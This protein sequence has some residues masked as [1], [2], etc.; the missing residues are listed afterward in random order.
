MINGF[1]VRT[2]EIMRSTAFTK[3]RIY[4]TLRFVNSKAV[5][6][7]HLGEKFKARRGNN[8]II[9][10]DAHIRRFDVKIL[11]A[12]ITNCI[13][14]QGLEFEC[15][16]VPHTGELLPSNRTSALNAVMG[17]TSIHDVIPSFGQ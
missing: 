11:T 8:N 17:S 6:D 14:Y 3:R 15:E 2:Q 4:K 10:I 12:A 5:E 1:T 16:A 7:H 9:P 13:E